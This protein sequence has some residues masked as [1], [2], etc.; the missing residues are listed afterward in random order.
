MPFPRFYPIKIM[1]ICKKWEQ[2]NNFGKAC[3][4]T[5][6]VA[7]SSRSHVESIGGNHL[8]KF[9]IETIIQNSTKRAHVT[10]DNNKNLKRRNGTS[11][12]NLSY[13]KKR[14]TGNGVV[15]Y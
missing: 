14:S 13:H 9:E 1:K 12:C 5:I 2:Q 11:L 4:R 6:Y 3:E 10:D 7:N 15:F 8:S